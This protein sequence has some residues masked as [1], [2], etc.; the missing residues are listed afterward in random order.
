MNFR[1]IVLLA[2]PLTT[3]I[4]LAVILVTTGSFLIPTV[5]EVVLS[6]TR[7]SGDE[8]KLKRVEYGLRIQKLEAKL[9]EVKGNLSQTTINREK[10]HDLEM[11]IDS[12][13]E[14]FNVNEEL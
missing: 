5:E 7:N 2:V 4:L 10:V 9:N 13:K 1:S 12:L 3:I 11:R 14:K 6:P 8:L